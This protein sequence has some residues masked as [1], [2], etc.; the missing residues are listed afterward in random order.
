ML[1][2]VKQC[3]AIKFTA[4]L[5][6]QTTNLGFL[7]R[8]IV[9]YKAQ[10]FP[11]SVNKAWEEQCVPDCQ[12][13]FLSSVK[14][15]VTSLTVTKDNHQEIHSLYKRCVSLYITKE[16]FNTTQCLN[17]VRGHRDWHHYP[18]YFWIINGV[19]YSSFHIYRS[20]AIIHWIFNVTVYYC[21]N[22]IANNFSHVVN[23]YT[24][25]RSSWKWYGP[26]VSSSNQRVCVCVCPLEN[27][28]PWQEKVAANHKVPL[29]H[30]KQ[31]VK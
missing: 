2:T 6:N 31:W 19:N 13:S 27:N 4:T 15:G 18:P 20:N 5:S 24:I 10:I 29:Q 1:L 28:I 14:S 7:P 11:L 3:T 26:I 22:L 9:F 21:S 23:K 30:G 17:T 12:T 8:S 25:L 16:V